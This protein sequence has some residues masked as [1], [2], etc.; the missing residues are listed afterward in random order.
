[1]IAYLSGVVSSIRNQAL[2]VRSGGF[3]FEVRTSP[4]FSLSVKLG[5]HVELHTRMHVR[6][7]EISLFGFETEEELRVFDSLCGV[8]GIGPKLA[9][10]AVGALGAA[11]IV[12]AISSG[13][14][15]PLL[16]TPGIGSKTAKLILLTLTGKFE[17]ASNATKDADQTVV[18]ALVGLGV[19]GTEAEKLVGA[20]RR[21]LGGQ[22]DS[23]SL[24]RE[25]LRQRRG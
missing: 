21:A 13:D 9:L 16:S 12:R 3:G 17:H 22:A 11:E 1:M 8:S 7:D 15:A 25:A 23:A 4:Q 18:G 6:E 24:L 2:V 10:T 5:D 19:S 14:E 20:S